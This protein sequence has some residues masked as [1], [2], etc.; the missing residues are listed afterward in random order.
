MTPEPAVTTRPE[1]SFDKSGHWY[2]LIEGAHPAHDTRQLIYAH[3]PVPEWLAIYDIEPFKS[4]V[5]HSPY[6]LR[7]GDPS[8]WL[9]LWKSSF[10]ELSGSFLRSERPLE[11]I[12]GHLRTL[13]SAQVDDAPEALF[14]FHD[15]WV[16]EA[17]YTKLSHA[18]RIKLH[19]PITRWIW[20]CGER[21]CQAELDASQN[22][23]Q[24]PQ[25]DGWLSLDRERQNAIR[26]GL[27]A[28]RNWMET[29]Q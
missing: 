18:E 29:S 7:L 5:T 19:G 2:A 8:K 25:T 3:I 23:Q 1:L 28:K 24:W 17:L 13:I 6:L 26:E 11:I 15:S 27:I 12:G 22:K 4:L 10:P 20:I 14:R 16:L 9:A 21:A